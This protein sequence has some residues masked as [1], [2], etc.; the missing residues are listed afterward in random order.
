MRTHQEIDERSLEMAKLIV[1]KIDDDPTHNGLQRARNTCQEW[2][3]TE[4]MSS[5]VRIWDEI[6]KGD[7]SK[8]R[9]VLLDQTEYGKRLRQSSP[10]V[11][12]ISQEERRIIYK[13]YSN[14]D[15]TIT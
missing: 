2:L 10:F 11:G 5:D 9:E 15:T 12:I 13:K 6:L 1:Q 3:S 7:W 8:V 14:Q 4:G